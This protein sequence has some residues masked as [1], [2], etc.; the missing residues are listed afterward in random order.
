MTDVR[1]YNGSG[2][3]TVRESST[4][5]HMTRSIAGD[6][7]AYGLE[8]LGN[9]VVKFLLTYKGT[10]AF[11]PEYGGVALHYGQISESFIPRLTLEMQ[12]DLSRCKEFIQRTELSMANTEERLSNIVLKEIRYAPAVDP[13]R[14]DVSI[15]IVTNKKNR[16][17]VSLTS[18]Q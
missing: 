16:A 9:K 12:N 10:D 14:V 3:T 2:N 11:N 6:P 4:S 15:E 8:V 1:L 18:R 17:V 7:V 5:E 13:G